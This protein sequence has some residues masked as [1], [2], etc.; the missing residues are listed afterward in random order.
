MGISRNT[1]P[2]S[3]AMLYTIDEAGALLRV[4]RRTVFRLIAA[5]KLEVIRFSDRATRVTGDSLRAFVRHGREA[6]ARVAV[7]QVQPATVGA[8]NKLACEVAEAHGPAP[9]VALLAKFGV[10]HLGDIPAERRA[11]FRDRLLKL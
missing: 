11:E 1:M 9:V 7:A 5:A 8:L 4:S 6:T 2:S 10:K 3:G